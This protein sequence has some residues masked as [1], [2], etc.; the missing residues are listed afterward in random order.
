MKLAPLFKLVFQSQE[1]QLST[2]PPCGGQKHV[3]AM[4][5]SPNLLPPATHPVLSPQRHQ[6]GL[7]RVAILVPLLHCP[8]ARQDAPGEPRDFRVIA[9]TVGTQGLPRPQSDVPSAGDS[10]GF[11]SMDWKEYVQET[12]TIF[13]RGEPMGSHFSC[14]TVSCDVFFDKLCL[15]LYS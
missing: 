4:A 8:R 3:I 12:P 10:S 1:K 7:H 6:L 9:R 5:N 15:F 11:S 14:F 2:H 13:K